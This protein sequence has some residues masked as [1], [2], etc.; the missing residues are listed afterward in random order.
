MAR[1]CR[2]SEALRP[3]HMHWAVRKPWEAA[4]PV[5][6]ANRRRAS[7]NLGDALH[8]PRLPSYPPHGP[9][10]RP[11]DLSHVRFQDSGQDFP[12]TVSAVPFSIV[13]DAHGRRRDHRN[14]G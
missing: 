1:R 9:P 5:A 13:A 8:R 7:E 14:D 6:R 12:S 4:V 11:R 2:A 10:D 3:V